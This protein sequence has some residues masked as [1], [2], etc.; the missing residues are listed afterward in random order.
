MNEG[1]SMWSLV[2]NASWLVQLVMLGLIGISGISW[3][4]IFERSALYKTT[5]ASMTRFNKCFWSGK[6]LSDLYREVHKK[7]DTYCGI[8]NVFKRGFHE[9]TRLRGL[10]SN[11]SIVIKGVQ[12]AMN[13]TIAKEQ[14]HLNDHLSFLATI[15]STSPYVGL[16]GT[17]VGVMNSFRGLA[18]VHQTTLTAVAPGIAEA[19]VT[20]AI[21][22][23]AAIPAVVAYN[24]FAYSADQFIQRYETFSEE[25]V[26]ILHLS[27]HSKNSPIIKD[28]AIES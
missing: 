16:F 7:P 18:N 8:E 21:G 2:W 4:Y 17:V 15:G 5:K 25:F 27:L 23:A 1:L 3:I 11:P 12:R 28:E 24:R 19:L 20:T 9:F 14:E 22:L 10:N 13:I 6:N 26:G